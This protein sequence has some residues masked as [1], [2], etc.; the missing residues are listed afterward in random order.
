MRIHHVALAFA[1]AALLTTP[2]LAAQPKPAP[3]LDSA[4]QKAVESIALSLR[5][6]PAIKAARA[7]AIKRYL[8]AAPGALEDGKKNVEGATD[9]MVWGVLLNVAN[10]PANPKVVWTETLPRS[11]GKRS[12]PGSRYAGDSPDRVYRG[13]RIDPAYRYEIRGR[14]SASPPLY[15]SIEAIPGPALWGLPP[16]NVISSNDVVTEDDG[17]FTITVDSSPANGRSNH[18]QTSDKVASLLLRDTIP[19]W[20]KQTPNELAIK[21]V[22]DAK[23]KPLTRADMVKLAVEQ[24]DQSVTASLKYF[25][26]IWS[27]PTNELNTFI[28]DLG[29]GMLAVN[30]FSLNDD[31]A[32]LIT[33]DPV[34][35]RY[36]S[37][38][39]LDP[40]LRSAA[41]SHR[42]T[43]MDVQ[44]S[45]YHGDGS[46]TYVV[47]PKDPGIYNWI[48]TG[49]LHDG[50]VVVRWELLTDK[51]DKDKAVREVRKV[52]INDVSLALSS[53]DKCTTPDERKQQL[54]ERLAAYEA[55]LKR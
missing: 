10:D 52:K 31:E 37:I 53:E 12:L 25:D 36:L 48:D 5:N 8:A 44:Q 18:L 6:D 21:R 50:I 34:S 27:R 20:G 55:R 26:G 29:W 23:V 39:T 14:R 3:I 46:V 24:I 41:Y 11:V 43:S 42:T 30:R 38:Q 54:A 1:A 51:A 17:S 33:L 7:A 28:R 45:Q 47:S 15:S 9:E 19:D 4:D 2:L 49:D 40:W 16:V 35:A 13:V 22:D 32:L